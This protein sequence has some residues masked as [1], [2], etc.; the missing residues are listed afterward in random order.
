M[1]EIPLTTKQKRAIYQKKFRLSHV[2][3]TAEINKKY[4]EANKAR[5]LARK[6]QLYQEAKTAANT[7]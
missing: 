1:P 5:I 3:L 7:I 4:Y 6:R 2:A